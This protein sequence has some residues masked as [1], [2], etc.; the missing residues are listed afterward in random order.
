MAIIVRK[1][2][3]FKNENSTKIHKD[4]DVPQMPQ[5]NVFTEI[6]KIFLF[7]SPSISPNRKHSD[8]NKYDLLFRNVGLEARN[9]REKCKESSQLKDCDAS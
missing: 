2:K 6:S 8:T 5:K 7:G 3:Y 9:L 4:H 1:V